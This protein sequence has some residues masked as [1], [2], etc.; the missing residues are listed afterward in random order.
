MIHVLVRFDPAG[1]FPYFR[2]KDGNDYLCRLKTVRLTQNSRGI[3]SAE[4]AY[5]PL[6]VI[7]K[8][9][10]SWMVLVPWFGKLLAVSGDEKWPFLYFYAIKEIDE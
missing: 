2:W 7:E 6:V 3:W 1:S 8:H 5:A 4:A 10:R 9:P